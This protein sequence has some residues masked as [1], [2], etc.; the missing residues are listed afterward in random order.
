MRILLKAVVLSLLVPATMAGSNSVSAATKQWGAVKDFSLEVKKPSRFGHSLTFVF[1][2]HRGKYEF[3]KLE[4]GPIAMRLKGKGLR[5][6]WIDSYGIHIGREGRGTKIYGGD[7]HWKSF[8]KK[9]SWKPTRD[10]LKSFEAKALKYCKDNGDPAEEI[11][12]T[13]NIPLTAWLKASG[14]NKAWVGNRPHSRV[15]MSRAHAAKVVCKPEPFEVKDLKVSVKYQGGL[16]CPKKVTLTAQFKANKPGKHK[17]E[18]L[19]ALGDG[20]TQWNS[21]KTYSAGQGSMARWHRNYTFKNS[22][23]RKYMV[24]V[25]GSPISSE[26]I[27]MKVICGSTPGGYQAAPGRN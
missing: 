6:S 17:I 4:G 24:T 10:L 3:D 2:K 8:D 27:P 16:G 18:F 23:N 14:K 15:A 20:T 5:R 19:L 12:G 26:W 21:V 1:K 25:K 11:V 13:V 9:V 7:G 22:V